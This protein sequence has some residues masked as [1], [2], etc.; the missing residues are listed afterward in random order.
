[1]VVA[2]ND[3]CSSG[4]FDVGAPPSSGAVRLVRPRSTSEFAAT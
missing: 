4:E 3:S 2:G 1:M